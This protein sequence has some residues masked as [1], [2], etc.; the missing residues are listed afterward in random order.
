MSL[1]DGG[2]GDLLLDL[3]A[4]PSV[5]GDE[6]ALA[7]WL[8]ARYAG[9]D[10]TRVGASLVVGAPSA[11]DRPTV[12]LVAHTDTVPPTDADREPRRDGERIVGRGASDMKAGLAVAMACFEERAL[13]DGRYNL[14]LVAYAAEEGPHADNE[15]G[16][17][18][19]A[20][21]ALHDAALAIVLEPTD[22]AVQL[23]CLGVL[24]AE[25]TFAGRAAHSARPWQGENALTKAGAFLATLHTLAPADVS[26]DDLVY[27]EV[28]TATQAATAN[29]RNVVPDRFVVNLNYRFAPHRTLDEA[30]AALR[31]LVGGVA[32]IAVVDRAAA[33]P[34]R[35]GDALVAAFL[36]AA[37]A[38]VEPK[39]AWTDVSRFTALGV[40]AL[41]YGPGLTGQAHQAGEYVL[42]A[43]LA[44]ARSAVARFLS[45]AA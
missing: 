8:A 6:G 19:D 10:V 15:L 7:D 35:R 4:I 11:P 2:L 44:V 29:A 5:T 31:D 14:A 45:A 20:V 39:Q 36:A 18:L 27:R 12:L 34:P 26:I 37:D 21:P 16:V 33:S 38:A 1:S 40:P 30:E 9:E 13:R 42:E 23:G 25:L 28:F 22:L 3:L 43:N 24:H 17:V 41:N 32:G